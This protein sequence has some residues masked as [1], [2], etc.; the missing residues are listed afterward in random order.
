MTRLGEAS[1]E[2]KQDWDNEYIELGNG[3][4]MQGKGVIR[5]VSTQVDGPYHFLCSLIG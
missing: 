5:P 3:V 1:K 4:I 2:H